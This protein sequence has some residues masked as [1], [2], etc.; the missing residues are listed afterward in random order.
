M[1]NEDEDLPIA[2]YTKPAAAVR[3]PREQWSNG[4]GEYVLVERLLSGLLRVEDRN[5]TRALRNEQT[6]LMHGPYLNHSYER[7][8]QRGQKMLGAD[9]DD[10]RK[11]S[12][13]N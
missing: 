4:Q 10:V 1:F 9:W 7:W 13:R 6:D 2:Q 3:D 12:T 5:Q 8:Y 11:Q